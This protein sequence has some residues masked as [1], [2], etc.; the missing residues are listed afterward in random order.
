[1]SAGPGRILEDLAIEL[2]R[3]RDDDVRSSPAFVEYRQRIWRL[4]EREARVALS[5]QLHDG[6]PVGA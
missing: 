4:L 5:R 2:P 6:E 1:M 3:P